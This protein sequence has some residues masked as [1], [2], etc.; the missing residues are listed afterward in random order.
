MR[1]TAIIAAGGIGQRLGRAGGK[2]LLEVAGKPVAAWAIQA[3]ADARGVDAVV[4][5]CDPQRVAGYE[6][7]LRA[8]V[9][10]AKP[11]TFVAGG[12]TRSAS[13]AAAL[14]QV[15]VDTDFVLIHDGARPLVTTALVEAALDALCSAGEEI[16]G[17]IVGHPV[18]D[19][20]KKTQG[21]GKGVARVRERA[22]LPADLHVI[23][24]T[25]TREGLWQV[26]TPQVF[27]AAALRDAYARAA[28]DATDDAGILEAAGFELALLE[29]PRDN[30]KVT[31]SEDVGIIEALL[32]ARRS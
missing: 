22:P 1:T 20:L 29:G 27:R 13:I 32:K 5:A 19:T 14:K 4:V 17:V 10:T 28:Q 2:Q 9:T 7:Q 11:L 16:A 15:P 24:A 26:Q 18:S 30:L 31:V 3:V 12:A 25:V 6:T 21:S 23:A 8:A